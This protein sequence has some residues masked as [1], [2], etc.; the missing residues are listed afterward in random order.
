MSVLLSLA[1][2][3]KNQWVWRPNHQNEKRKKKYIVP[4]INGKRISTMIWAANWSSGNTE[5][6]RINRNE[7]I[8]GVD[9]SRSYLKIIKDYLPAIW[10]SDME[11]I[12][13]NVPINKATIVK[14]WFDK[15]SFPLVDWPS[16]SPNLNPTGHSWTVVKDR[17]YRLYPDLEYF[18]GI[19]EQLKKH[20]Y[21]VIDEAWKKSGDDCFDFLI[22]H[23]E[24]SVNAVL[25]T[26][27]WYTSH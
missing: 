12:H 8:E 22:K 27:G 7:S 26:K 9:S 23:M 14:N 10:Q 21:K 11:F 16:Y 15:N 24:H 13:N 19:K 1:K 17:I 18:D 5:I 3:R 20:F 6:Y 4:Y 25:K 2:K